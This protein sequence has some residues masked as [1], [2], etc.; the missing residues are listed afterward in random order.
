MLD[1]AEISQ[2]HSLLWH[3]AADMMA[4]MSQPPGSYRFLCD[5]GG[6]VMFTHQRVGN[7]L[8]EY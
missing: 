6:V 3:E 1:P 7:V 5:V 2:V 8:R 4:V